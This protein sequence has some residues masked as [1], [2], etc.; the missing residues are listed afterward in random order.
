M[1]FARHKQSSCINTFS[2]STHVPSS[3]FAPLFS[4]VTVFE[5]HRCVCV[6]P[7]VFLTRKC[8]SVQF[9]GNLM[10]QRNVQISSSFI[11]RYN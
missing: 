1:L 6:P 3:S 7:S 5:T 10:A 8:M 2:S 4:C 9:D 11:D